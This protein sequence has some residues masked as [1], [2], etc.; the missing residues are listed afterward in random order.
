[1]RLGRES[2]GLLSSTTRVEAGLIDFLSKMGERQSCSGRWM[3]NP[4]RA[5]LVNAS[6]DVHVAGAVKD[7]DTDM[8]PCVSGAGWSVS[9]PHGP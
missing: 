8:C 4:T 5:G 9:H 3:A 6:V 2:V 1:M 7:H